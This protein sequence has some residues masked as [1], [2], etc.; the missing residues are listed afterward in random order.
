EGFQSLGDDAEGVLRFY[1]EKNYVF[2]CLKVSGAT[3]DDKRYMELH[4]LR[5]TFKPGRDEGIY[6][7][8]KLTGL[9]RDPFNINLYVFHRYWVDDHQSE[10]GYENRG[11]KREYRDWDTP[12]CTADAGKAWSA[13]ETD[14]FLGSKASLLPTVTRLFQKLHPGKRYYLTEI[15]GQFEPK[16]VRQWS[17]DLWLETYRVNR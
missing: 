6:F 13:P 5:F 8:M 4:P 9:Q 11:F 17:D 2:A 14:P 12:Q 16:D 7:L 1:R 3:P 15:R 10:K